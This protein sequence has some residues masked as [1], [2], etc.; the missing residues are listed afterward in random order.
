MGTHLYSHRGGRV[1]RFALSCVLGAVLSGM[2]CLGF[3][4]EPQNRTFLGVKLRATEMPR[5]CWIVYKSYMYGELVRDG[6]GD[7][8]S[9]YLF[10]EHD[11]VGVDP[12]HD[13]G[14]YRVETV[15]RNGDVWDVTVQDI[16]GPVRG[17][18]RLV[19]EKGGLHLT[20][21][22]AWGVRGGRPLPEVTTA[23]D[24][25]PHVDRLC[26]FPPSVAIREI[27]S[28]TAGV[29]RADDPH[30]K[31]LY[32]AMSVLSPKEKENRRASRNGTRE[33]NESPKN[34]AP[35][36]KKKPMNEAERGAASER[37]S[38]D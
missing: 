16:E 10:L 14:V 22:G 33:E 4:G 15:A 31:R 17:R 26:P 6:L 25:D 12:G 38:K 37:N 9:L 28:L 13:V 27:H 7:E 30:V 34:G 5:R 11:I 24:H 1:C 2:C 8:G 19:F 18:L 23:I 3:A 32:E 35:E 29:T 21:G 36:K 20:I